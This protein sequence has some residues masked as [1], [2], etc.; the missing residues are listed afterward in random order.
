MKNIRFF[1]SENIHFLVVKFSLYLNTACFRN[2]L[3]RI[4]DQQRPYNIFFFFFLNDTGLFGPTLIQRVVI[5]NAVN[6]KC[7]FHNSDILLF[8][9]FFISEPSC[10][11][12]R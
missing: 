7:C 2:E 5:F 9:V 1:F 11:K 10:S 3:L 12:R 6:F 4:I 8:F